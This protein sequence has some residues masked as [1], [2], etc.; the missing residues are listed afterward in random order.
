M[1]SAD[2]GVFGAPPMLVY[3]GDWDVHWGYD[4]LDFDPWPLGFLERAAENNLFATE[5]GAS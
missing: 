3:G 5:E 1:G 2:F 4:I